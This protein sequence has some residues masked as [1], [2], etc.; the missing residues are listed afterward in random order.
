MPNDRLETPQDI[1][2]PLRSRKGMRARLRFLENLQ[3]YLLPAILIMAGCLLALVVLVFKLAEPEVKQTFYYINEQGMAVAQDSAEAIPTVSMSKKFLEECMRKTY[4]LSSANYSAELD[5][6]RYCFNQ[7]SFS[8]FASDV[9]YIMGDLFG[10]KNARGNT[11]VTKMQ[12]IFLHDANTNTDNS[13]ACSPEIVN[14][15]DHVLDCRAF[16]FSFTQN[17]RYLNGA[18]SQIGII[19]RKVKILAFIVPR[20]H[21]L[22]GMYIY[23]IFDI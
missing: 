1:E 15:F 14:Q 16:E 9:D 12:S 21:N 2:E 18:Q 17:V 5:N 10:N 23:Q 3:A 13:S 11:T 4:S 6:A 8:R 22:N 7:V 20:T 19:D